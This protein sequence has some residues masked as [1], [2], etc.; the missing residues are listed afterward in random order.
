MS[1]QQPITDN[2]WEAINELR[3]RHAEHHTETVSRISVLESQ[4]ERLNS[5]L[6]AI[7]QDT[8]QRRSRYLDFGITVAASLTTSVLSWLA[9]LDFA[10]NFLPNR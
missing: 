10:G 1:S 8:Q 9:L 6:A 4:Q 3:N 7:G 5:E 2:I